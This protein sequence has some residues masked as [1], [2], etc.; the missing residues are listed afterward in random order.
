MSE[1]NRNAFDHPLNKFKLH[2]VV[3]MGNKKSVVW[4]EF[5]AW[6]GNQHYHDGCSFE[7]RV[8][9]VEK[10]MKDTPSWR[11]FLREYIAIET[12]AEVSIM[13]RPRR[14]RSYK[15]G[16]WA[17]IFVDGL[18]G[19]NEWIKAFPISFLESLRNIVEEQYELH[20]YEKWG[21]E[22]SETYREAMYG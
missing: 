16:L 3:E 15:H 20:A 18:I 11:R 13:E 7:Q 1:D 5:I 8:N 14:K 10:R 4:G 21:P 22:D 6:L 19:S 2:R 9:F 17:D 12:E